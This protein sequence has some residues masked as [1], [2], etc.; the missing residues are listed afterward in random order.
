MEEEVF[1]YE[2]GRGGR[3]SEMA[4]MMGTVADR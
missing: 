4:L 2:Q 3:V 1:S